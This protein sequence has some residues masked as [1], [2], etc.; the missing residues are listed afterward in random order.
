MGWRHKG[1]GASAPEVEIDGL[2]DGERE[3]I[4]AQLAVAVELAQRFTGDTE[5]VPSLERLDETLRRWRST[6]EPSD[7]D[8]DTVVNALGI[9]YGEHVRQQL[10]LDWVIATDEYGTDL[11]LH[12]QPGDVVIHPANATAKRVV[13]GDEGFFPSLYAAMAETVGALRRQ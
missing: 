1:R 8:V 6:G 5:P 9:A 11:A 7:P 12:G 3:W 2:S 10:R 13:A 4:G